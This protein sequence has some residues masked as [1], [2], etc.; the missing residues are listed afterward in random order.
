MTT[1]KIENG[2]RLICTHR[3]RTLDLLF[4]KRIWELKVYRA[5]GGYDL[6]H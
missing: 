5:G 6:K 2:R 1:L 3:A 4:G